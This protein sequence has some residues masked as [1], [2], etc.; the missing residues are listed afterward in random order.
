[1][2]NKC[3]N[4]YRN[5]DDHDR[6][7]FQ[8]RTFTR[9]GCGRQTGEFPCGGLDLATHPEVIV[10]AKTALEKFGTGT[11][12]A[13]LHNGTTEL[14]VQLEK[15]CAEFFHTEDAVVLSAGYLANLAVISALADD[16]TI[17][18][19]DQYNHMSIVDGIALTNAQVR[20]FQHNNLEK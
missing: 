4:I 2:S 19:T 13:R 15:A 3:L 10:A 7:I 12:G 8:D 17:I 1:M 16:E 9:E 18:I 11:C 5:E 20:I 6:T 14:H